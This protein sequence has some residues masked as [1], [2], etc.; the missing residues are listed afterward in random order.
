MI[1]ECYSWRNMK[2]GCRNARNLQKVKNVR[3]TSVFL[4]FLQ[5]AVS[6]ASTAFKTLHFGAYFTKLRRF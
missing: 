1:S 2:K 4:I 5:T 6:I 3:G